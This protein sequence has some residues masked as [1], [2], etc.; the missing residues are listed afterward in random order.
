M[1]TERGF[2]L[3][4]ALSLAA[5]QREPCWC[6]VIRAVG[7]T[8]VMN[9]LR[10]IQ[11]GDVHWPDSAAQQLADIKDQSFPQNV[12]ER[13]TQNALQSVIREVQAQLENKCHAIVLCGDLTSRGET[14]GYRDCAR[15]LVEALD[16][17]HL[18][19]QRVHAVPGNHD[20]DRGQID[21]A[22]GDLFGKFAT[23]RETWDALSLPIL[24]VDKFR[25]T[26]V[27]RGKMCKAAIF[28]LNSSVGCGERRHLP[29]QI[30]TGLEALL[31]GYSST[32]GPK[33]A[34]ALVGE[35]LDTPAFLHDD[36]E[37]ICHEIRE[38][39]ATALP[40]VVAHHNILPQRLL[41]VELYTELLNAGVVRSRLSR[42]QRPL[43]YC[44]GHIHDDPLEIVH[45]PQ[46]A[47]SR[48]VCVSA[49][50]LVQGF[51]LLQVEFGSKGFPLGCRVFAFR[52]DHHNGEVRPLETRVPLCLP[53]QRGIGRLANDRVPRLLSILPSTDMRLGDLHER[54]L[55]PEANLTMDQLADLLAEAEWLGA[56]Q[57]T[58]REESPEY[59]SVRRV[60]R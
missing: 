46:Y 45:E 24:T 39:N 12:L 7:P 57:I 21:P 32:A 18:G 9:T 44:H 23:C 20:V 50:E 35:T 42:L 37:G 53:D 43:L 5:L 10:I 8:S 19:V 60:A 6:R 40:I 27:S 36:V 52:L 58:N 49:P 29:N 59:R 47:G 48:V 26:S 31:K 25:K 22:G 51:N 38:L 30:R 2:V 11:I 13:V 17:R 56:V 34:F 3:P 41:R 54:L 55:R 15:Y 28:S 4:S 1:R 33:A 16:L 14:S